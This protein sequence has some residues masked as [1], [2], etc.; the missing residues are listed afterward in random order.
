MPGI[1]R[2]GHGLSSIVRSWVRSYVISYCDGFTKWA[3]LCVI[4]IKAKLGNHSRALDVV[5]AQ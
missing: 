4:Y 5:R 3:G 1:H 2:I